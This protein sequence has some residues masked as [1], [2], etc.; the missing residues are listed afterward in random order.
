MNDPPDINE[1]PVAD[2]D[3]IIREHMDYHRDQLKLWRQ[4]RGMRFL[5][6]LN[7][8]RNATE[9]A[10][11]LGISAQVVYNLSREARKTASTNH[12]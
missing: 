1:L 11:E 2:A 12:H 7:T 3:R 9:V 10:A 8:G 6:E 4:Q 5:R